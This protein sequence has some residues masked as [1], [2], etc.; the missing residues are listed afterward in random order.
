MYGKSGI[1]HIDFGVIHG[2]PD[3]FK[4]EKYIEEFLATRG[5][6]GDYYS[7]E[8]TIYYRRGD[9]PINDGATPDGSIDPIESSQKMID[10]PPI[11]GAEYYWGIL[12][13][14]EPELVSVPAGKFKA[15]KFVK[16]NP[17]DDT[18]WTDTVWFVPHLGIVKKTE[19]ETSATG[20]TVSSSSLL[21]KQYSF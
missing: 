21:L 13:G 17:S 11:S 8:G 10:N 4:T 1:G 3:I 19:L 20:K 7:K 2:N 6:K 16:T 12:E 18:N 14:T 15:W 5:K 9:W